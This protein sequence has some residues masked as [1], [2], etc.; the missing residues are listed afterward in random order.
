LVLVAVEP[1]APNGDLSDAEWVANPDA[2]KAEDDV[3]GWSFVSAFSGFLIGLKI[4]LELSRLANGDVADVFPNPL[5]DSRC[6]II[7]SNQMI[8]L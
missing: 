2:A 3:C 4:D 1:S 6:N 7:I 5:V 8:R